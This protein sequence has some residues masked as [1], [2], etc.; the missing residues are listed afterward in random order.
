MGDLSGTV[1]NG[2]AECQFSDKVGNKGNVTFVFKEN[3]EIEATILYTDK[4]EAYKDLSLDGKYLFR[5][6]NLSDIKEIIPLKEHSFQID[7]NSWG[8]V[9]FVAGESNTSDKIHPVA[10]LTNEHGDIL[11]EFRAS[12]KI[13]SEIIEASI[14]DINKDGLK[15]V[16]ITTDFIYEVEDGH[17]EWI[18]YQMDNGLFYNSNLDA[19]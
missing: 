19:G 17:I 14:R 9:N 11:Y 7:L 5:P 4:G 10:Y 13:G 3:D 15:D 18:F 1:N 16:W 2:V 6:Y 8:N 12:F